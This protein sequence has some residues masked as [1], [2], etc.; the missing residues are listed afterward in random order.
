MGQCANLNGGLALA[1]TAFLATPVAGEEYKAR[2]DGFQE[3]GAL[4]NNPNALQNTTGAI[5][6]NGSGKLT[7][8]VDP[9]KQIASYALTFS[10]LTTNIRQAHLH[11]GQRHVAG[12]IY[13]F[14]CTNLGNGPAG[15]PSCPDATQGTV[16][17]L[18]QPANILAVNSQNITAGDF[19]ALVL[20]LESNTTYVN[21]HTLKFPAG[22]IRGQVQHADDEDEG[23]RGRGR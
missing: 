20:G 8:A 11:F 4:P 5:L 19:N 1:L 10:G 9:K 17:G 14:L 12:G 23:E 2:L 21:V 13:V 3:I 16:S 18:I 22:E 7:L 15:T 6:T